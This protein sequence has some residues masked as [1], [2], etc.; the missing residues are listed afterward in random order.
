MVISFYIPIPLP[1]LLY[2]HSLVSFPCVSFPFI[3]CTVSPMY[4]HT[5]VFMFWFPCLHS[6]LLFPCL[7]SHVP[8]SSFLYS[9]PL[10]SISLSF[11][12]DLA[13]V[14]GSQ[15]FFRRSLEKVHSSRKCPLC[16]RGFESES[17]L[18]SVIKSVSQAPTSVS[19]SIIYFFSSV[20][21]SQKLL[22][23]LL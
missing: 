22:L 18:Q 10:I 1:P 8:M 5:S 7:H 14:K 21:L 20:E 13:T 17:G 15:A 23:K 12:S 4:F 11:S 3:Y 19:C 6:I 16:S 9:I 2:V